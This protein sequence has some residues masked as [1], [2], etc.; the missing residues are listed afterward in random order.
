MSAQTR[1]AETVFQGANERI[2]Y[3]FD[4]SLWNITTPTGVTL[5]VWQ[6][7]PSGMTNVSGTVVSGS[8]SVSGSIITL[9]IIQSLTNNVSYLGR[10]QFAN[11]SV[12][13]YELLIPI[14]GQE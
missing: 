1:W 14:V 7:T 4:A 3:T 11:N 5:T 6:V 9:P 10:L 12:G 2:P 8:A 13:T